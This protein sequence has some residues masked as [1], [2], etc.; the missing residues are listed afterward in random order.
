[1]LTITLLKEHAG[2]RWQSEELESLPSEIMDNEVLWVDAQDPNDVE[3]KGLTD[4]FEIDE[5]NT[6]EL[7]QEEGR[8]RIDEYK[9][10]MFCLLNFPSRTDF[11]ADGGMQRL[12]ML[13]CTRWI[14]TV[15]RGHSELTC[16]VSEKIAAHGYFSLSLKPSTDIMLY[17]FLDLAISEYFPVSDS[18]FE[19]IDGL[20]RE[21]LSF[22]RAR[23][24]R[25][26]S[27]LIVKMTKVRERLVALRQSLSPL[28]EITSRI[29]RGEFALVQ[30]V[31]L[32]RFGDLY[33]KTIQLV[34][35]VDTHREEMSN[36][37]DVLVSVQ[38]VTTNNIVRIL[39]II[40]AIFLP[41]T[42]IAGIYGT[43]FKSGIPDL[44]NPYGFYI[45][46]AIMV[47]IAAMLALVFK[48]RKWI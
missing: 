40:S 17:I 37:R 46:I 27:G 19:S 32:P 7:T 5:H 41:L 23:S 38:T 45:L 16:A 39:T 31:N 42:L 28:R 13:V 2:G 21:A 1:M 14:V 22:F 26:T 30:G 20:N 48:L 35:I 36:I 9:D 34:E 29:A 25:G 15:H 12:A 3:I 11:V 47:T 4:Y 6:Q 18:L 33:D 10:R 8:S 43:N 24:N 44:S